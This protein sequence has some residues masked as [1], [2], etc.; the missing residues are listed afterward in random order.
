[1]ADDGFPV[2]SSARSR[3]RGAAGAARTPQASM[4][5]FLGGGS[6]SR[7]TTPTAAALPDPGG[8]V[9]DKSGVEVYNKPKGGRFVPQSH[10]AMTEREIARP[11][12]SI[13]DTIDSKYPKVDAVASGKSTETLVGDDAREMGR[14]IAAEVAKADAPTII[15]PKAAPTPAMNPS[16]LDDALSAPRKYN[17][18]ELHPAYARIIKTTFNFDPEKVYDELNEKLRFNKPIRDMGYLELSEA[19][20]EAARLHRDAS[21]LHAHAKVTL[22]VF[23]ADCEAMSGDMRTQASNQLKAEKEK[24]GGKQITDGDVT[25]RMASLFP[26]EYRRQTRMKA[27]AKASAGDLEN[28]VEIWKMRRREI[29]TMLR[30]CRSGA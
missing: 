17:S 19:L 16:G 5:E 28:L 30:E 25:A 11:G 22:A 1:M 26:D 29:D 13:V 24:S 3:R 2:A 12:E 18:P 4:D 7:S 8:W 20:D 14:R 9:S 27:E 21:R 10:N 6:S 15:M 23:E